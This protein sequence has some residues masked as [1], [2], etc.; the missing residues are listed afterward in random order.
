M[1]FV[2][3]SFDRAVQ[4]VTSV[5]ALLVIIVIIS[6]IPQ[7]EDQPYNVQVFKDVS[8]RLTIEGIVN[9]DESEWG[10]VSIDELNFGHTTSAVWINL[11]S[12]AFTSIN[13]IV[14]LNFPPLDFVDLFVV[15][16]DSKAVITHQ[17]SGDRRNFESKDIQSGKVLFNVVKPD[18]S[19]SVLLR[20]QTDG[21]NQ[22][23]ISIRS[24]DDH[25]KQVD[26]LNNF[27][28]LF[29]GSSLFFIIISAVSFLIYKESSYLYF[30][31]MATSITLVHLFNYRVINNYTSLFTTEC[32]HL[33]L[34]IFMLTSLSSGIK[35]IELNFKQWGY[36]KFNH[37][38]R[39]AVYLTLGIGC[40]CL[41]VEYQTGLILA[42]SLMGILAP[43]IILILGNF[44]RGNK[45]EEF[46]LHSRSLFVAWSLFVIGG[47]V[48]FLGE[49]G[50]LYHSNFVNH[51]FLIGSTCIVLTMSL[52]I[53]RNFRM[54]NQKLQAEKALTL[55]NQ[56]LYQTD[57]LSVIST[58][59]SGLIHEIKNPLNWTKASMSIALKEYD[60][61]SDIK[62]L[63][64]DSLEGIQRIENIIQGLNWFAKSRE[65]A[66]AS[67]IN[68]KE[69]VDR[70]LNLAKSQ[71]DGIIIENDIAEDVKVYGSETHLAQVIINILTN[72][73]KAI[74]SQ[75]GVY[76]GKI[77]V[78][79]RYVEADSKSDQQNVFISWF[80]NGIGIDADKISKLFDPFF[81]TDEFNDG[82]G[83]GMSVSKQIIDKHEGTM[84]ILSEKG[85][86][87]RVNIKL[88]G[89]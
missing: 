22:A 13:S 36:T 15:D 40:I 85:S 54:I 65:L 25:L 79:G 28:H 30:I 45:G 3:I 32:Q 78:S 9:L 41:F 61:T 58:M 72:S 2:K 35:F 11:G 81:T 51:V 29:T 69:L 68:L 67:G 14:D 23:P 82:V 5:A 83:L 21:S 26:L 46:S 55:A 49:V 88:I 53:L 74:N 37:V 47:G 60:E 24:V 18:L 33:L 34:L 66:L 4:L 76:Q 73:I 89:S 39:G 38:L 16:N 6:L 44:I 80:D 1:S 8:K 84:E 71:C 63:L 62:E 87:T 20:I 64:E 31:M 48:Q 77:Q 19:F 56:K 10:L 17:V 70:T 57:K 52:I 7:S 86:W 50:F 27:L 42:F 12:R 75:V 59:S 43:I